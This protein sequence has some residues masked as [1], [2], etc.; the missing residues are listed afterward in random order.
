[1]TKK[2][3]HSLL[4]AYSAT[5]MRGVI[6]SSACVQILLVV[7]RPMVDDTVTS[8]GT[9]KKWFLENTWFGYVWSCLEVTKAAYHP[10]FLTKRVDV[11]SPNKF[12]EDTMEEHGL[13]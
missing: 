9:H 13:W 3:Y 6:D 7:E 8:E 12:L 2:H 11:R 4:G 1:M 5:V 10:Y